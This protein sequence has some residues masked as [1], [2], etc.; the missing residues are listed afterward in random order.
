MLRGTG[1]RCSCQAR[2]VATPV[3][4]MP[5]AATAA[6]V[7]PRTGLPPTIV[8]AATTDRAAVGTA[9]IP[10]PHR[11]RRW[12]RRSRAAGSRQLDTPAR[13]PATSEAA[14]WAVPIARPRLAVMTSIMPDVAAGPLDVDGEVQDQPGEPDPLGQ[15][16]SVPGRRQRVAEQLERQGREAGAEQQG[17]EVAEPDLVGGDRHAVL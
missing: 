7:P 3:T 2:R 13:T 14:P 12:R 10:T 17:P 6:T 4:H 1:S 15:P 5:P 8:S 16:R 9:R 11:A